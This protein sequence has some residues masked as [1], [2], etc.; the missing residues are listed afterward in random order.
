MTAIYI[1]LFLAGVMIVLG[2]ISA[3][4]DRPF[5]GDF[6]INNIP[7]DLY[8]A[9]SSAW[10]PPTPPADARPREPSFRVPRG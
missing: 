4:E 10:R 3:I 7:P 8:S 1:L 9:P 6:D 5:Y 2:I